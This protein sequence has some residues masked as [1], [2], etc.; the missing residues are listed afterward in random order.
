MRRWDVDNTSLY[1]LTSIARPLE[2]KYTTNKAVL[3]LM[4]AAGIVAAVVAVWRGGDNIEAVSTGLT[5][6]AAVFGTWALGRELAPDHNAAA[7]IGMA[8]AL[9]M[10]LVW[11]E[12]SLALIFLA[13]FL[14]RIVNRTVGLPA[15][16]S[17]SV[18]VLSLVAWAVYS[19][20]NPLLGALGALAFGFDAVLPDPQRHQ[21][22]F[23]AAG[24]A[25]AAIGAWRYGLSVTNP[26]T[27]PT[28]MKW[29]VAIVSIGFLIEM[30]RTREPGSRGDATGKP[31]TRQ[32]VQAGMLIGWLVAV[33]SLG[34]GTQGVYAAGFVW[35][36]I[37]GVPL[38]RWK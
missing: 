31:L 5:A 7:F 11:E 33:Q 26:T 27:L 6:V 15:R 25:V 14:V 4:P 30:L 36:A 18:A 35:A 16:L 3:L 29:F 28:G 22:G 10:T 2:P 1:R 20:E 17:D 34:S 32:R 13:L 9:N 19:L 24:L 12:P 37:A 21:I 8:L 23:A 38:G